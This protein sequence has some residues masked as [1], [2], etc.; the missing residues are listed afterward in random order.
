MTPPSCTLPAGVMRPLDHADSARSDAAAKLSGRP[1]YLSDRIAPG[2]LRGAILG[3]PHPHARIVRIDTA[4]ARALPGVQAVVTHADIPGQADYG[5]RRI[6]RPALC[7]DRVRYVGDAVA[8][9]AADSLEIAHAALDLI[10]VEYEVLPGVTCPEAA[11]RPEA[12]ALHAGGNLL[13]QHHHRLGDDDAAEVAGVHRVSATYETPRQMHAFLETEGG[14]AEPDG[15][16]G[17]RLFFA[18]HN[19]ERERQVI[20][21]MLC[22]P[23][24]RVH[25]VGSP[26]GG[27]YGGKDELTVQPIAALLAWKTQRSVRLHLGRT[28]S[29]DFGVK[30]HPM[31]IHMDS[32]CDAQGRLTH[33]RVKILADTGAYATHGPEVLDAALEHAPG[34][35]AWQA[36]DIAGRLAYT[37]NGVAGAFRGFGAVQVQFALEQQIDRLALASGLD[38]A[39]FRAQNLKPVDAPGP[40]GQIVLPFDGPQRAL[41]ALVQHPLWTSHPQRHWSAGPHGRYRHGIGLALVHRSDGFGKGFPFGCRME[42][43]LAEDG[44]IELRSG[45][46]ELGQNLLAAVRNTCMRFLH[47]GADDVRPVLGDT[48]CTPD[49]GPVAASRATT[50]VWHALQRAAPQWQA[51]L[52]AAT[53]SACAV[54]AQSLRLG[55]GGVHGANGLLASYAQLARHLGPQRPAITI[56]QPPEVT[57]SDAPDTH[58]VFGACAAVAHA[59][60][61]S[62]TGSIRIA[63]MALVGAVGPVVS[64]MGYL[65]QLEGGALMGQALCTQEALDCV[66]GRYQQ[67]NLDSYLIPTLADAPAFDVWAIEGLPEGDSV[68]PRGTGEI[69]VN[70]AAPACANAIACALQAPVDSLPVR[71]ATVFRLL[72]GALA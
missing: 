34:P 23:V 58:Y 41:A 6:D 24:E 15:Q 51:Q 67:R 12:P 49:S 45:F 4:A 13:H 54:R 10:V 31:R 25:S 70:I 68:G 26:V 61:D 39:V 59:V 1:V 8:G 32:G 35:Y 62:W 17:L 28:Q 72:Q 63:E 18:N 20:A 43:A 66:D 5:L 65:G 69:S 47:C 48:R 21:A 37:N 71:P 19:P 57:P 33:H 9:V 53:A 14:V 36:V 29:T 7:R 52:F 56:D 60:I 11:L 50:L 3:S 30:R 64:P 40:L 16:G 46:T 55:V 27:S 44:A 42:L 38:P 2:Q 22:L